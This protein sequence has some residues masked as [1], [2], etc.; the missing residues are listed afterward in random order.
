MKTFKDYGIDI[1]DNATGNVKV[2]C[3]KCS[4]ER[5][6]TKEPCLSVH[7]EKGV[8]NCHN[9][10]WAGTL[11][12]GTYVQPEKKFTKPEQYL[13]ELPDKVVAW[14]ESRGISK[15]TL[16]AEKIGY[17]E[18]WMPAEERYMN[19]IIFP[20]YKNGELINCKFRDGKKNF[21]QVAGAEKTWFRFDSVKNAKEIMVVEGEMDALSWV[22]A[23]VKCVVSVPDGAPNATAKNVDNKLHF[24]NDLEIKDQT[25]YINTDADDPGRR[26]QEELI[27]RFGADRC[28]I[29]TLP[30]DCK[31][32]NECLVK[33]GKSKLMDCIIN[34]KYV[35]VSGMFDP[36]FYLSKV[37]DLRN[38]GLPK[39]KSTGW[40]LLDNHYTIFKQ[41]L[42]IVT[43]IPGHGKS[44]FM[45]N[46]SFNLAN[47]GFRFAFF[48][49]EKRPVERHLS[50]LAEL[51]T[52]KRF[53]CQSDAEIMQ[54]MSWANECYT[55]IQ[56][57]DNCTIE[58]ILKIAKSIVVRK[59]LDGL[60]IDPYN[61]LEHRR[62][63]GTTTNEFVSGVLAQVD[64]F[65]KDNDVAAWVVAHPKK[66]EKDKDGSYNIPMPYDISDSAHWYNYPDSCLTVYR[67]LDDTTLVAVTKVRDE[68]I[69]KTG[70]VVFKFREGRYS[71]N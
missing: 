38:N 11:G 57:D 18:A 24:V 64:S 66:C 50:R 32:A 16:T 20:Y 7:V 70:N 65:A 43:G 61:R 6:K 46:L 13:T 27:K 15:E 59:G 51:F 10:G 41:T 4:A 67:N 1:R 5:K 60:I 37:I 12:N 26:L 19:S 52:N 47:Q 29:V 54:F 17:G 39:G 45:D 56:P 14:F 30:E 58:S 49:P 21:A 23:G 42:T 48:T 69:G 40:G 62:P 33:H 25:I 55:F 68:I 8:W 3:P 63:A 36:M 2:T 44:T 28:R 71:E 53:W 22:E 35:Q 34:A 31:D 9:C